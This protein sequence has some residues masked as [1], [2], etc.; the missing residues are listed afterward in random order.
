MQSSPQ[1]FE[2]SMLRRT[3][4]CPRWLPG[5]DAVFWYRRQVDSDKFRFVLVNCTQGN[6]IAAFNHEG[7]ARE[8]EKHTQQRIEPLKLPFWWINIDEDANWV[9]FQYDGKTWQYTEGAKLVE[10]SGP[11]DQGNFDLG[12]EEAASPWSREQSITTLT[13]Q[14]AEKV[15]Y[16]WISNDGFPQLYG[17]VQPGESK[18]VDSWIGHKW[19]LEDPISAKKVV[20]ELKHRRGVAMVEEIPNGLTLSWDTDDKAEEV[21]SMM[22]KDGSSACDEL[23]IKDYNVWARTFNGA[24]K[25]LTYDGV[26]DNGYKDVWLSPRGNHAVAFQ[27]KPPAS[28]PAFFVK[29]CPSDQFQPGLIKEQYPRPGDR[30]EYQR[31]RLF[32][33]AKDQ[34]VS[35]DDGLFQNAFALTHVGWSDDSQKYRFIFNERG[36]QRLR[37]LEVRTDGSVSTIIEEKSTTFI[38][39]YQKLYYKLLHS[40]RELLWASEQDGWNHLYLFSLDDGTL[41]NQVTKGPWVMRSV[42]HIDLENRQIWF[43]GLGMVPEQDPYYAHLACVAFD[44]SDLRIVTI[45]DG[46][47]TWKWGP[48]RRFII[49]SWSRVDC[50]PQTSVR[51]ARTGKEAVFL[52]SESIDA[53]LEQQW[54]RPERFV[55]VGRDGTT[56]IYGIII[57]PKNLDESQ[58]YPVVEYIYAGPQRF[59][60]PKAFKDLSN[61]RRIADQGFVVVCADGKGTNWRSKAFHDLCYKNLKDAGFLDRMAWICSAAESRPW[62]DLSRVG[63][64]GGSTG[65]QNAA[66]AVIHHSDFYKAAVAFSG[67][68]DNRLGQLLWNEM[69]MGYPIDASYEASSNIAHA[70]KLGGAL[71]LVAGELDNN[72]DPV[73]TMRLADALIKAGK[74]F[75]MFYV[76]GGSHYVD[77]MPF[78]QRKRDAFF[79]RHLQ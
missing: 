43:A 33:L 70:P 6:R 27:C 79:R 32:D 71:M 53:I 65:G 62:M 14:T 75:D 30:V 20:C 66:A 72:V 29:S 48:N 23:F 58:K 44:G 78:V 10:W 68:H 46:T 76:P 26:E 34:E 31:L 36:H 15:E 55:A 28:S 4:I 64:Y 1:S 69:F 45:G 57:R 17:A 37:L 11:F 7:L 16:Y 74:D 52:Q 77:S 3:Q 38:D 60:A 59:N 2:Q 8:L 40:T 25:Q 56:N 19:R 51:E 5:S 73:A 39:Y 50:L 18:T 22:Q 13:N 47:H 67:T 49:D 9:R 35:V 61:F 41:I 54:T 42:E 24:E 21:V 12:C 63:C